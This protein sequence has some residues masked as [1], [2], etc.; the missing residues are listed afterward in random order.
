MEEPLRMVKA[1]R[2]ACMAAALQVY[3]DAGLSGLCQEG[4]WT[5]A[6][7]AMRGLHLRPLAQALHAVAPVPRCFP[8]GEGAP[9]PVLGA[10]ENQHRGSGTAQALPQAEAPGA[11]GTVPILSREMPSDGTLGTL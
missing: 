9:G 3:E 4:R 10:E 1:V 8:Q 6:V 11:S 7:D 5:Y 2:Q